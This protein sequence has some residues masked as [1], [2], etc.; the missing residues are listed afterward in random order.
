N[1]WIQR[2]A[3]L[4]EGGAP[5]EERGMVRLLEGHLAL[6]ADNDLETARRRAA[7]GHEIA[8]LTGSREVEGLSLGLEGLARVSEGD[9]TQ[10]MRL[11][12]EAAAAALGGEVKDLMAVGQSCCYLIHACERVRDFERAG[13]WCERVQEFCRRWRQ[14]SMLTVCR[15]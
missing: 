10:G 13:Q 7:E 12:D 11:L 8:R 9:V 2:A 3:R 6:M 15:T 5:S 4:L 14:V 1:G